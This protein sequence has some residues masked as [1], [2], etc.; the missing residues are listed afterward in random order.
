LKASQWKADF[1]TSKDKKPTAEIKAPEHITKV[2]VVV[3]HESSAPLAEGSGATEN[4]AASTVQ[5]QTAKEDA[6]K[7]E[8]ASGPT[9][10]VPATTKQKKHQLGV[11]AGPEGEGEKDPDPVEQNVKAEDGDSGDEDESDASPWN[12]VCVIGLRVFSKDANLGL[13]LEE[14]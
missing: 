5:P 10:V 14:S 12:A 8:Q 13:Q 6:N 4:S 11:A 3:K 9:V 2:E 1:E 7:E